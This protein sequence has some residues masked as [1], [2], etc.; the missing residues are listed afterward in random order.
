MKFIF[1]FLIGIGIVLSFSAQELNAEVVVDAQQT[2]RSQL[3]IFKT[4]EQSVDE[5]INNT[6]WT[7]QNLKEHQKIKCS[8]FIIIQNYDSDQFQAS[9]QVRSSRPVFGST[10][11]T[12]VMNINDGDFSFK[13]REFE[14]L[15]YSTNSFSSNLVSTISFYVYTM[16]GLDADTF[17]ELGGDSYFEEARQIV[18]AASQRGGPGWKD[19]GSSQSRYSIN[20]DLLSQ[21]F[22]NFR[23]GLYVYHRQGLDMM[24]EDVDTGKQNIL[25]AVDLISENAKNRPN[26][27]LIRTFFD[28]KADEIMK[29]LNGGPELEISS[30]LSTLN[31]VA[32]VH[33]RT[34]RMIEN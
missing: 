18:N 14:P 25:S 28:A 19:S 1:T 8:F 15:N 31:Q 13:Y 24:Y 33:S 7:S 3:S 22:V 34:W 2:G 21:N 32:P 27:A 9:I 11:T 26:S 6:S 29:V 30:T 5:F 23:K 10:M 20:R 4:L 12:P 16:L 17:S